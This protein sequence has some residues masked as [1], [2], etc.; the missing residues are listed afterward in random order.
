MKK[1][2]LGLLLLSSTLFA[3]I[4]DIEATPRFI[5]KTKLKIIDIRTDS[6]WVKHGIIKD[7]FLL[8]FFDRFGSYDIDAFTKKLDKIID[9]GEKFAIIDHAGGRTK[10]LSHFLGNERGYNVVNLKGGMVQLIKKGYKPF[11]NSISISGR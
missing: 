6:E 9:K 4:T 5:K 1:L 2:L 3:S 10:L 7:A 8:T 11:F